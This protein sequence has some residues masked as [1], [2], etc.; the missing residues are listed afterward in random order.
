MS[1]SFSFLNRRRSCSFSSLEDLR[2]GIAIID[3]PE[4]PEDDVPTTSPSE[5]TTTPDPDTGN[6]SFATAQIHF[7]SILTA[8]S[9]SSSQIANDAREE[10]SMR[11]LWKH[12]E[13]VDGIIQ[14]GDVP[15]VSV[16]AAQHLATF[17]QDAELQTQ[18]L[19]E[20]GRMKQEV[21]ELRWS[22]MESLKDAQKHTCETEE[23]RSKVASLEQEV[24]R[25]QMVIE[26]HESEL[27]LSKKTFDD[28][29]EELQDRHDN[30]VK[31]ASE[32]HSELALQVLLEV[33][34]NEIDFRNRI[35]GLEDVSRCDKE[36]TDALQSR[37][38]VLERQL[39]QHE[40]L[41]SVANTL[42]NEATARL[43]AERDEARRSVRY[44]VAQRD[45]Q[46]P[47]RPI[48][49]SPPKQ[50]PLQLFQSDSRAEIKSLRAQLDNITAERN[51]LRRFDEVRALNCLARS[52]EKAQV[53]KE[54]R[55]E[56]RHRRNDFFDYFCELRE[57]KDI[58][59]NLSVELDAAT[60]ETSS[61]RESTLYNVSDTERELQVAYI[62][63][64]S[65]EASEVAMSKKLEHTEGVATRTHDRLRK[66][67]S[68]INVLFDATVAL[69]N[70]VLREEFTKLI[71]DAG[72]PTS[73]RLEDSL[74]TDGLLGCSETSLPSSGDTSEP[75]ST[76]PVLEAAS[77]PSSPENVVTDT[78]GGSETT[79]LSSDVILTPPTENIPSSTSSLVPSE[80]TDSD[81]MSYIAETL[82]ISDSLCLPNSPISSPGHSRP[83]TPV[84]DLYS[85]S[86]AEDDDPSPSGDQRLPKASPVEYSDAGSEQWI[87]VYS[88]SD[89]LSLLSP[90]SPPPQFESSVSEHLLTEC[91]LPDASVG[92]PN[93]SECGELAELALD[94]E[95]ALQEHLRVEGLSTVA[96]GVSN[97]LPS[98]NGLLGMSTLPLS[99]QPKPQGA[100][101]DI[102]MLS[103][104]D[105][106][107]DIGYLPPS[108]SM[109][110]SLQLPSSPISPPSGLVRSRG[111]SSIDIT[112]FIL[113]NEAPM[114]PL[115]RTTQDGAIVQAVDDPSCRGNGDYMFSPPQN[116][117]STS[118]LLPSITLLELESL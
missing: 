100:E 90:I 111:W 80:S 75:A 53:Q 88:L 17:Q 97:S 115:F 92:A 34:A 36:A 3:L 21:E 98:F 52:Q 26:E 76:A 51:K 12:L 46:S 9:Q 95:L 108:Y 59:A 19:E 15:K 49:T 77:S 86:D 118:I 47:P 39:R 103:F 89:S 107:D 110:D 69:N 29:Y 56:K 114:G 23:Q 82:S 8:S 43:K 7:L 24:D 31:A 18:A 63:V 42:E 5:V 112:R 101:R 67:H 64:A 50:R 33:E 48:V 104:S 78:P 10:V 4:P 71:F 62:R 37:V 68:V 61:E 105:S 28:C 85:I 93:I 40:L 54:L 44:F 16:H 109:S 58:I 55:D 13:C 87:S 91:V 102:N 22:Y 106:S 45:H 113:N 84:D 117:R 79:S 83:G 57:K 41:A 65:L 35:A 74:S 94:M 38:T 11:I 81:A 25:L 66:A 96:I 6:I 27:Q 116:G 99:P 30:A 70:E 60:S 72:I 20:Q 32:D 73:V 14:N 2:R 1:T